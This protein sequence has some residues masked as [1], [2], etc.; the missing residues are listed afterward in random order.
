M[1]TVYIDEETTIL[2]KRKHIEREDIDFK[3]ESTGIFSYL[4]S[5]FKYLRASSLQLIWLYPV[6][7]ESFMVYDGDEVTVLGTLSYD[8]ILDCF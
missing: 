5:F 3:P 8:T 7:K 1:V 4:K 6:A 2:N